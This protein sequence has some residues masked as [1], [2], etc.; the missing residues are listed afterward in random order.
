MVDRASG[1]PIRGARLNLRGLDATGSD[2]S[3]VEAENE[4][5]GAFAMPMREGETFVL[6]VRAAGYAEQLLELSPDAHRAPLQVALTAAGSITGVVTRGG[7]PCAASLTLHRRVDELAVASA[8]TAEAGAYS[9]TGQ[10]ATLSQPLMADTGSSALT[11]YEPAYSPPP[12]L[13]ADAGSFTLTGYSITT[14]LTDVVAE[15]RTGRSLSLTLLLA[16]VFLLALESLVVSRGRGA[17][18]TRFASTGEVA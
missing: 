18:A 9:L 10:D 11:L 4:A 15:L 13:L 1:A 6:G 3:R 16:V 8:P 14:E 12:P 2:T 7:D 5:D 17:E